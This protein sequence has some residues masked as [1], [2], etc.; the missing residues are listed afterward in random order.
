MFFYKHVRTHVRT[1]ARTRVWPSYTCMHIHTRYVYTWVRLTYVR[2]RRHAQTRTH[3]QIHHERTNMSDTYTSAH[4]F[5]IQ[6]C[7][8]LCKDSVVT[9]LQ[10][11][12]LQYVPHPCLVSSTSRGTEEIGQC[13]AF[14]T[15]SA[16]CRPSAS[17]GQVGSS[18]G[19]TQ[20]RP[21]PGGG[22]YCRRSTSRRRRW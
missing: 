9:V 1:H 10:T 7:R 11:G 5:I 17:C 2:T 16:S 12:R 8:M 4:C 18:S 22:S 20:S 14:T 13:S 6:L 15:S 21:E 19:T 3:A